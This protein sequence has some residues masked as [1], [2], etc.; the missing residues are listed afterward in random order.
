M[1][2]NYQRFTKCKESDWNHHP[3]PLLANGPDIGKSWFLQ[4]IPTLPEQT[5]KYTNNVE[6][7][8]NIKDR[9]YAINAFDNS[10]PA[11]LVEIPIGKIL[12]ILRILYEYF[13]HPQTAH[14]IS[15]TGLS[16]SFL[17]CKCQNI[18]LFSLLL[19]EKKIINEL[20]V[21]KEFD[22]N[23]NS[24]LKTF[25]KNH[26]VF[27]YLWCNLKKKID[28]IN[29]LVEKSSFLFLNSENEKKESLCDNYE[30]FNYNK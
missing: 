22:S 19:T 29:Q 26:C 5:D 9:I 25:S 11:K 17:L 4:K 27:I 1:K 10:T 30:W 12:V 8:N 18:S 28:K 6:L 21:D 3:I 15:W 24:S 13:S 2:W 16:W 14:T 20:N 7:L 23:R